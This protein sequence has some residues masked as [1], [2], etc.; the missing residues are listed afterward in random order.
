M[1]LSDGRKQLA[2]VEVDS[3]HWFIGPL[4]FVYPES[5]LFVRAGDWF[6]TKTSKRSTL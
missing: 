6:R 1:A 3:L 5:G 4:V 2:L